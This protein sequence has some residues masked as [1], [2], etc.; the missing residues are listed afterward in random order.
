[1]NTNIPLDLA[2]VAAGRLVLPTID[3]A[4][5]IGKQAQTLR[6]WASTEN[7]PIL[8]VRINGRLGWRVVDI[9]ALLSGGVA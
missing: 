7:G 9:A 4:R 8:P 6:K 3:A 1:M 2:A 5:A